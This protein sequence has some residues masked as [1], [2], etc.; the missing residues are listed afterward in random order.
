MQNLCFPLNINYIEA[1][2]PKSKI[3]FPSAQ[4]IG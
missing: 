1:A 3:L 4:L 2:G